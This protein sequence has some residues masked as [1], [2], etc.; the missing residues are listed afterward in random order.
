MKHDWDEKLNFSRGVRQASD[1]ASIKAMI[2]G[3]VEV[4]KT[5]L[6]TDKKGVDYIATL[7]RGA[8]ILIDAKAREQG[9]SRYWKGGPP[10]LALEIWS[11]MAGGKYQ[12]PANRAKTGWTL[13]EASPVDYIYFSFH[14]SDSEQTFLVAFQLLR[15]AFRLHLDTWVTRYKSEPP[16]E[17]PPKN[18]RGGWQSKAVYVPYPVVEDAIRFVGEGRI[19]DE[20]G[21]LLLFDQAISCEGA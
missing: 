14:P 7:R 20:T 12:T 17:T 15:I 8:Q 21:G 13:N 9:C 19:R 10:E 1:L 16:Q 18:G 5:D 3:C 4:V 11:V 6:T 2:P